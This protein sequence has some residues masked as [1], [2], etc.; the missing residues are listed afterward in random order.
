MAARFSFRKIA[1]SRGNV[2][3]VGVSLWVVGLVIHT[4]LTGQHSTVNLTGSLPQWVFSCRPSR[5]SP[6]LTRGMYVRFLPPPQVHE[7]LRVSGVHPTTRWIKRVTA[8]WQEEGREPMVFVEG[9]HPKSFD[10]RH[11]GPL[12]VADIQEVCE[13]W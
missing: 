13:P 12:R 1:M 10:S 4:Q 7:V 3:A 6:P 11:W 2:V 8:V 5:G 9:M